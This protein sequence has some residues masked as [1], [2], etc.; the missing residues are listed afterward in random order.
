MSEVVIRPEA[1]PAEL[2]GR[3]QWLMWSAANDAPRQPLWRGSPVS[4]TDPGEWRSFEEALEAAQ[5]RSEWGIGYVFANSND[6]HAAGIYG[7]LDLDGCADGDKRPK[8][9]LPSLQPFFDADAYMEFSPSETGIHIPLVGFEPPDWWRDVH[10]SD[11]EHEGVEAYGQ[12]FFTFTGDQVR[13]SGDA[14]ADTGEF[15]EDWLIEAHKAITGEDPT[16]ERP[17]EFDDRDD[18]GRADRDEYLDEDDIRA[19]LDNIDPDVTYTTWRDIGFA[20]ADFFDSE[21]RARRVFEDW[22]RG[23]SKWDA[24]AERK[25]ERIIRDEGGGG[26]RER[27]IGTVI[28]HARKGGWEMPSPTDSQDGTPTT[29]DID[30]GEVERGEALLATETGPESPAGEM[31]CRDGSYGYPWTKTDSEGEV[32]NSGFD[33][34]TNFTLETEAQLDTDEGH[35]LRLRVEPAHPHGESFTVSVP[36]TVFNE[37]RT[38]KEEVVSGLTTRF[39]PSRA[40][41]QTTEQVLAD[42]RE[43]VGAQPAPS[44]TGSE[45]IGLHG[46][47][48]D[49]WVSPAGTLTADG[50]SEDP[51]HVYHE[52]GGEQDRDS[53]LAEKWALDAD[54]AEYDAAEVAEIVER[55]PWTRQVDRGLPALAWFYAAALKPYIHDWEGEFNL[56]QVTGDTGAGKTSW[57]ELCYRAFGATPEPF[58]CGDTRFTI[59]KKLAGSCGLPIWFDEYK[60]ADL[61]ERQLNWLHRR[62]REVTSEKIISKGRPSLGEVTFAMRAPVVYS[63]EQTVT[64][65]AV[66]RR[67]VMTHF[68]DAATGGEQQQAFSELT[69]ASYDDANGETHYPEGYDLQQ[70]AIAFYRW[71][72]GTDEETLHSWWRDARE[73]TNDLLTTSLD[74]SELQGLQTI[75][76]GLRVLREFATDMG[77]DAG[78][79]PETVHLRKA[80]DH[81]VENIGP[82][83]R[84]REHIDDFVELLTRAAAEGYV[85]PGVDHRIVESRK[86]DGEVLAFHMPSAF[87]A[88]KKYVREFNVEGEYNLLGKNDYVDSFGDKAEQDGSYPLATNKKVRGLEN[89]T[90]AVYIDPER[91]NELLGDSFSLAAFRD[92]DE[93]AEQFDAEDSGD[94]DGGD[95]LPQLADL[96]PGRVTVE[97]TVATMMDPKP[98][99]QAEGELTDGSGAIVDYVA[100]G[101]ENVTEGF[102]ENARYRIENAK[103]ETGDGG[104]LQLRLT[105]A[106]TITRL[107]DGGGDQ[108]GLDTAGPDDGGADEDADS[109]AADGGQVEQPKGQVHQLLREEY[110]STAPVAVEQVADELDIPDDSAEH[111]LEELAKQGVVRRVED[112]KYLLT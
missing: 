42:L 7:A 105:P 111:G 109:A 23:G 46:T 8:E 72:C 91:A 69:G 4:W 25:A 39:E 96:E 64:A 18:G 99:L 52:K 35:L 10:F 104:E 86:Y 26:G 54:G 70:H 19:A 95:G 87:A 1:I 2:K 57:L 112:G 89:G 30:E 103:V 73:T 49:E 71:A 51:E 60:P 81:V 11:D 101:Q 24:D 40:R 15:V 78:A 75:A 98:W 6:E 34:V 100:R 58:G 33:R 37:S 55:L 32:I 66:R 97:A 28:H 84:R 36:P 14:V 27:T 68:T 22:S 50:W 45:H 12:K 21:S 76:F 88:V 31:E 90:K 44:Y 80:F 61:S 85:E 48:F 38:F 43:T 62:L 9:W 83:G 108:V 110:S 47:G 107:G 106:V 65:A 29:K 94:D 77:A 102:E 82:D 17:S 93:A 3:D 56:L 13:N 41:Y 92:G 63:G 16:A 67:T 20:L 5:E 59:E 79:L 74:G 53:S